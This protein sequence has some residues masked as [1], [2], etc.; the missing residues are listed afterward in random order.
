MLLLFQQL[1]GDGWS[2]VMDDLMVT[3]TAAATSPPSRT[4]APPGDCGS[5]LAL[6]Y[7]FSFQIIGG[8]YACPNPSLAQPSPSPSPHPNPRPHHHPHPILT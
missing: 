1:T 8:W 4:R 3:P 2:G 5:V 6:P 7:F